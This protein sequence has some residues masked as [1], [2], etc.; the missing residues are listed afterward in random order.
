M[1]AQHK[2]AWLYHN[3]YF[4]YQNIDSR[5]FHIWSCTICVLYSLYYAMFFS[6]SVAFDSRLTFSFTS[7]TYILCFWKYE[8][9][10]SIR[11]EL[12][13]RTR[14]VGWNSE[15]GGAVH[16]MDLRESAIRFHQQWNNE[17][18]YYDIYNLNYKDTIIKYYKN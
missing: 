1:S 6:L 10:F 7:F 5:H 15:G 11:S 18:Y 3:L 17:E 8:W 14:G 16:E 12:G 4:F 13:K 2:R 9:Q